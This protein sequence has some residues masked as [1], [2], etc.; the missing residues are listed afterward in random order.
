MAIVKSLQKLCRET[1]PLML[2]EASGKELMGSVREV[3]ATDRWNSFDRFHETTETLV[4]RYEVAG[5]QAEVES[6]QTG[7]RIG[8]GRWVIQEACDVRGATVDVVHPVKQRVLDWRENPWH[9][10][11]WSA[12]TPREGLRL[13]LVV[14]D[15]VTAIERLSADGLAGAIVLTKLDP[16]SGLKLLADKGAAGVIVDGSV[17]NL[18]DALAWTKFGWGAIPLE[19]SSARL[20]G[21]VLS[22]KQG[23]KL[24]RLVRRH[25]ELTLQVKADIR[26]YVGSH[27]VVS[28]VIKGAGDPQDEV[29]AI[30]HSAEPG[31]VD[32]A[33]GVALTLE[34]A[35]VVEGLIRA[36]KIQRPRRTI[37]LLNAYE[38]YGFFAYLERV[39]RLQTPLAGVCIDT[40]GSKPEVCDGRLEWHASIPMSAGFVDRIGEAILRSGVRRHRPGYTVCPENFMSTS[41]TLIGDPQ[42]GFPCPWITT[43][44]RRDGRGFDA[45]HSSA[46]VAK[47]L[48]PKGLETCAASMAAY[49]YYLADMGSGEA[50]E[51]VLSENEYFVSALGKKKRPRVETEYIREAHSRSVRRLERWLWGGKRGE[52]LASMAE[53]ERQV[54][55]ATQNVRA[56]KRPRQSA[57][58]RLVPRRTAVLSPTAENTPE[59]INKKIAGA[60]LASWALFWADG[61]R[62][63]SAI[64]ERIACEEID[65]GDGLR[66]TS[67]EPVA[68]ERVHAYFAAHAELGYVELSDPAQMIS[69]KE[70]VAALRSLGV[71]AGMD[72]M[73]HSSLSAIGKVAG[74]AE[75]VI[76]ALLQAVG[77]RGTLLLP[78]FNHRAAN[79]YNPLTTPTTNGA[80]PDALWRRAE[81]VR[82]MHPTH[83]VAAI[84]PRAEDYCSEHLEAGIWAE[85]SPIG[86]LVHG[87][88]YILALG[89]THDTSTAYHVAE[90]S[91]P[92]RCI[93]SFANKDRIVREDGSVEE[94][95]GL[96]F[97]DGPCP[98]P[99]DRID[100]TL[101]RRKLQRRGKVGEA[102]CELVLAKDLWQV[103]R[104]HVRRICPSCSVKPR[105]EL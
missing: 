5:A 64:A 7:G 67:R 92:C 10:I 84:G 2:R 33:S 103:R 99:T 78:S 27:D 93:A 14:I 83:A 41:D 63:L 55:A 48:S 47:L 60:K 70:L 69:R 71:E 101:D 72:L 68:I 51:L 36:G 16:R 23:E 3:S 17:R 104:E 95:L 18:P 90:M 39:R 13:R 52:V 85:D 12:G 9:V 30:A 80:I 98:V 28:G 22:D 42:Y 100:T 76:D 94:V 26:K 58:A 54:A 105:I 75:T 37:R 88:G 32:N 20:V 21:F 49:L 57:I 46:D 45:Y 15:E 82:S 91:V 4:R 53:G 56:E 19:R 43:H 11:Q 31:A 34:I 59:A 50:G 44:H 73:V 8:S 65:A 79:V 86:K 77:R 96:A 66:N 89:T 81:A 38:C 24:R 87:G 62:D 97:R 6:I 40:V 1:L 29:W 102:E 35:R 61:R 25:G 74:G